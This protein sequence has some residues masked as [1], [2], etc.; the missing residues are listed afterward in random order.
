MLTISTIIPAYNSENYIR[1]CLS[2]LITSY[3]Q[4]DTKLSIDIIVIND[5]S[6]D[7]TETIVR[8]ISN[9][10]T[11]IKLITQENKGVSFARN[12]GI[13]EAN[14]DY[15]T[16]LDSDDYVEKDYYEIIAKAL[17]K[18]NTDL[19]MCGYSSIYKR[20]TKRKI[21][22]S[23]YSMQLFIE[24]PV[25]INAVGNK[26]FKSSIIKD[27]KISFDS[28]I[29]AMEDLLFVFKFI[30]ASVSIKILPQALYCYYSN[31]KSVTHNLKEK[32]IQSSLT[33]AKKIED[34][35]V[36]YNLE[37]K[38]AS[39][40][41]FEKFFAKRAY[42]FENKYFNLE[43]WKKTFPEVNDVAYLYARNK[44]E[45]FIYILIQKKK[46]GFAHFFAFIYNDIKWVI[47]KII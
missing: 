29:I 32:H 11:F 17:D 47:K 36:M 5:G 46:Y 28:Q 27:R 19:L 13:Q 18:Q 9:Q 21:I 20:H 7:S 22:T 45:R 35:A 23:E 10:Y 43:T 31:E 2:S 3:I 15:I 8:E 26:V 16:F 34:L 42:L 6:Q 40:I 30:I 39:V 25:Y 14:G 33:A 41:S 38:Y 12:R 24:A 1:R 44:I 4:A 37:E